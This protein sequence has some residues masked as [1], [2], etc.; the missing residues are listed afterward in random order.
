VIFIGFVPVTASPHHQR[1]LSHN[2][3][4]VILLMFT[5]QCLITD[6]KSQRVLDTENQTT[7]NINEKMQKCRF[8]QNGKH[9]C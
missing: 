3:T 4:R 2:T 8:E 5:F 7:G 9:M 6:V 1:D